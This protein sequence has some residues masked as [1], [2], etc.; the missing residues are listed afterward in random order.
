MSGITPLIDTLMHQVLGRQGEVSL[1]RALSE[2][3]KAIPPGE[4]PRALPG[5]SSLDGRAAPGTLNDLRRLPELPV[6]ERLPA[7]GD[8]PG[9]PPGSTQTHFSPAARTIA[10][11]LL[12][13]PAPVPVIRPAAPLLTAQEPPAAGVVAERLEASV[14]DSGL[15]YE[16]HLKRWFQG[17]MSRQQ[18]LREP[19]M[20]PGPR[21]VI[22][23]GALLLQP[24]MPSP[25]GMPLAGAGAGAEPLSSRMILPGSTLLYM[26]SGAAT[27]S[28]GMPNTAGAVPAQMNAVAPGSDAAANLASREAAAFVEEVESLKT[29]G[30]REIIHESL[31]GLVRQQLDMLVMPAIR[32]EGDVWAGIFMALVIQLPTQDK[33]QGDQRESNNS[34]DGW[35]SEMRLEVP[36]VGAFSVSLWFYRAVLSVDLTAA[37][38]T[39]HQYLERGIPALE[40]RLN[41]LDLEKVQVRA[42]HIPQEH[43]NDLAG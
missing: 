22:L 2:P 30:Q 26:P 34:D 43:D 38:S 4:G 31:Q 18:L 35:R 13:F 12:R 20:Q 17:D 11:V 7:R 27:T 29:R 8:T 28:A 1:Q 15:F 19:Q 40:Q 6:G 37:D 10:D 23:P 39:T 5:D 21:P 24:S 36:S 33:T 32:W 16:A 42:R 25:P 41:A 14:R 3:V 9:A